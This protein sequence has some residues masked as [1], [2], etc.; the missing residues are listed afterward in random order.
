MLTLRRNNSSTIMP[1][2]LPTI[3]KERHSFL[4]R[5]VSGQDQSTFI[6]SHGGRSVQSAGVGMAGEIFTTAV[7]AGF[8]C[9]L[10]CVQLSL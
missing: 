5:I 4:L 6:F 2:G 7:K 1:S 10:T 8:G 9:L 3:E